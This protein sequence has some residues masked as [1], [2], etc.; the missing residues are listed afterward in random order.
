MKR[1][2]LA[3]A[4][5]V[6][7][8]VPP[9]QASLASL[10]IQE[11]QNRIQELPPEGKRRARAV[12][13]SQLGTAL[14]RAGRMSE[15]A[16]AFEKALQYKTSRSL[17][18][19]IYLFLGKSYESSGRPDKAIAA[20]EE[21][22]AHDPGNPRR[23]RDL[24]GLYEQ[25]Q[26][27]RKA[28]AS[29]EA[30]LERDPGDSVALF[31]LGRTWRK[32]GIYDTAE[33]LL[34][35]ADRQG[36]DERAVQRE[37]SFVYEGQGRFA[38]A[39]ESWQKRLEGLDSVSVPDAARGVYLA[40]LA[41]DPAMAGPALARLKETRPDAATVQLYENLVELLRSDP[42]RI[43]TLPAAGPGVRSLV[44]SLAPAGPTSAER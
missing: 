15:A 38:E 16:D 20:Y 31:G 43:L 23:H 4:L 30:G 39:M 35:R 3:V 21:A 8:G 17:R 13:Y 40:V 25:A 14:Y 41:Q 11:A 2:A 36:H 44:E 19:H 10:S 28:V 42:A 34:K 6:A 18:R 27:Y 12:L 33:R 9:L 5:L 7:P 37:L 26:L 22:A 29:Y 24:A 32:L 1:F